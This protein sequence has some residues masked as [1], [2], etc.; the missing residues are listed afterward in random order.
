ME[1][2]EVDAFGDVHWPKGRQRAN[3]Q[4]SDDVVTWIEADGRR[5]T[6]YQSCVEVVG[7]PKG[8]GWDEWWASFPTKLP[9]EGLVYGEK[10]RKQKKSVQKT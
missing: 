6:G 1:R 10:K 5:V 2:A 9:L 4:A 3:A 7:P 8:M